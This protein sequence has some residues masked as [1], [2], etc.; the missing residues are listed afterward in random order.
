MI[1]TPRKTVSQITFSLHPDVSTT[2][3]P[4]AS[5]STIPRTAHLLSTIV[6]T[7]WT[8]SLPHLVQQS[9]YVS[10]VP[11]T[12]AQPYSTQTSPLRLSLLIGGQPPHNLLF[13]TPA[14]LSLNTVGPLCRY[15]KLRPKGATLSTRVCSRHTIP[16]R[17]GKAR[18]VRWRAHEEE[19]IDDFLFLWSGCDDAQVRWSGLGR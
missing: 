7:P 5:V 11:Q 4:R 2:R 19:G 1:A 13:T 14:S 18:R 3:N 10:L 15:C 9:L 16:T 12:R 17:M 6:T 8:I